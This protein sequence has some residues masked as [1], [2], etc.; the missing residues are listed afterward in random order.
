[1]DDAVKRGINST[2]Y[3]QVTKERSDV[4]KYYEISYDEE[5]ALHRTRRSGVFPPSLVGTF[6]PIYKPRSEDSTIPPQLSHYEE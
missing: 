4:S 5:G 1:V 6:R 2:A 3:D